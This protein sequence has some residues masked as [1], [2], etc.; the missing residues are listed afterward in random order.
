MGEGAAGGTEAGAAAEAGTAGAVADTGAVAE[1]VGP[2]PSARRGAPPSARRAEL[3]DACYAYLLSHG[4]TG[5]SLRPLAAATGTSPRVLLYLFGSKDGLL[6]EL[7]SRAR[8][9]QL[10]L[11]AA[12]LDPATAAG[13]EAPDATSASGTLA[14]SESPAGTGPLT[15]A[16]A[17]T[18][19]ESSTGPESS[20]DPESLTDPESPTGRES[21]TSPASPAGFE[22][23]A[24][25]LWSWLS[26][27]DRRPAVRLTYEAFL[28]S[29]SHQPGPWEGFAAESA[30]EWLALLVA[31]QPG[32]P[33]EA[34]EARA[35]RVL[36][37]VRGLL[38]DLLACEEPVRVAAAARQ[39]W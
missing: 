36:A 9:E 19:P 21:P 11:V 31:A 13:A 32:V 39:G 30:R 10:A 6:R 24:D 22:A 12:A 38:I 17:L 8:S 26:A 29:L 27:P 23:L 37:L 20:T 35:T 18:R 14:G 7:L 5:L 3:L 33:R 16:E 1:A 4:L 34:A 2:P 25:R 28:L 15:R